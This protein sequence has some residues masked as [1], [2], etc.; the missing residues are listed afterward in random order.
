[1][2]VISPVAEVDGAVT[3]TQYA[4]TCRTRACTKYHDTRVTTAGLGGGSGEMRART[5]PRPLKRD[6]PKRYDTQERVLFG[7][8]ER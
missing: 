1:M 2:H 3:I 4:G 7:A 8:S 6:R 5:E